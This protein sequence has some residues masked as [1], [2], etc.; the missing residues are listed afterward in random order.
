V[1]RDSA[2]GRETGAITVPNDA[3][4]W[5]SLAGSGDGRHFVI[6]AGEASSSRFYRLT[7]SPEGQPALQLAATYRDI[8]MLAGEG[9]LALSPDESEMAVSQTAFGA[10]PSAGCNDFRVQ[11]VNLAAGKIRNWNEY[12]PGSLFPRYEPGVL[13]WASDTALMFTVTR[14]NSQD[15][16][17]PASVTIRTLDTAAPGNRVVTSVPIPLPATTL[18]SDVRLTAVDGGSELVGTSCVDSRSRSANALHGTGVARVVELSAAGRW[19]VHEYRTQTTY[20]RWPAREQL[21][22]DGGCSVESVDPTGQNALVLA[23]GLGRFHDGACTALPGFQLYRA[24][25]DPKPKLPGDDREV[26]THTAVEE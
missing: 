14:T 6:E 11:V 1:V 25:G 19:A 26:N 23:F 2:N 16:A 7:L 10:C 4:H 8:S 9:Q 22:F 5:A 13:N 24:D 17:G 3:G 21:A 12:L 15:A 20:F 18:G